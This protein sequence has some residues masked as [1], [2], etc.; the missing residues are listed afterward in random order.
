MDASVLLIGILLGVV[1][2]AVEVIRAR[3]ALDLVLVKLKCIE[4]KLDRCIK[5]HIPT[6]IQWKVGVPKEEE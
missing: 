5:Q 6:S 2:V 4:K 1:W 3:Y